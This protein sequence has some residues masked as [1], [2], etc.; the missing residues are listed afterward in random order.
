MAKTK[1]GFDN[2]Q[3]IHANNILNSDEEL[4]SFVKYTLDN[5]IAAI[6]E[7]TSPANRIVVK[8]YD[9]KLEDYNPELAKFIEEGFG[10]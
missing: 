1:V 10:C 7:L 8:Y 6:F 9:S 2:D 4:K 3:A 5:R